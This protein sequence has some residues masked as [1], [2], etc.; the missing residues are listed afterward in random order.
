MNSRGVLFDLVGVC[1]VSTVDSD[2]DILGLCCG[3]EMSDL[4][5]GLFFTLRNYYLE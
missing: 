1:G 4:S 2:F 5:V 3:S